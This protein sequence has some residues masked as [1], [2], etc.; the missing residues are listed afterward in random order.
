MQLDNS[1][2]TM[3][4]IYSGNKIMLNFSSSHKISIV[5]GEV[6]LVIRATE[7]T[8]KTYFCEELQF[9]G[10]IASAELIVLGK[11]LLT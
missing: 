5:R 10:E 11:A 4:T 3:R 6:N 8:A 2:G 9:G 1:V 7:A